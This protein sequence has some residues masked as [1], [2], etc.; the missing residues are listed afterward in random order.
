[1]CAFQDLSL[2]VGPWHSGPG[3]GNRKRHQNNNAACGDPLQKH[4]Q[5][6]IWLDK[7]LVS[8]AD[9]IH[10]P[11]VSLC[12]NSSSCY[13]TFNKVAWIYSTAFIRQD[14]FLVL[15]WADAVHFYVLRQAPSNDHLIPEIF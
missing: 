7:A 13:Y 15:V 1:M 10:L 12:C 5:C 2:L 6:L 11:A 8:A 9:A 14:K 3:V 4:L